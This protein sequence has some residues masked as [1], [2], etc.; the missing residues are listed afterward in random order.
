MAEEGGGRRG[1][2]WG[3]LI[4]QVSSFKDLDDRERDSAFPRAR[5][6]WEN[7]DRTWPCSFA[8]ALLLG[9]DDETESILR[10]RRPTYECALL[11]ERN[12]F[13]YGPASYVAKGV[14]GRQVASP[15]ATAVRKA[16]ME[17]QWRSSY[18]KSILHNQLL[19]VVVPTRCA[20]CGLAGAVSSSQ[21]S[22][23]ASSRSSFASASR[24]IFTCSG[25][26]SVAYCDPACQRRGWGSG[27]HKVACA[28]LGSDQEIRKAPHPI[29]PTVPP[30]LA[31]RRPPQRHQGPV[32]QSD[33]EHERQ[34]RGLRGP[35]LPG[36]AHT[37]P[38]LGGPDRERGPLWFRRWWR[39]SRK[40]VTRPSGPA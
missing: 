11:Q 5:N 34:G 22:A 24:R 29:L 3:V 28:I 4:C 21:P 16:Q 39:F 20:G 9:A 7:L 31:E 27:G 2:E 38:Q 10:G 13:L 30:P 8:M 17:D 19:T 35:V 40:A 15:E 6:F 32:R 36:D 25:C 14:A 1:W 26:D 12:V 23:F 37:E 33:R 18:L